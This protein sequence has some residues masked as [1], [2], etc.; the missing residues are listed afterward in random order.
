M[1]ERAANDTA[2]QERCKHECERI[3]G[4]ADRDGQE[5]SPSNLVGKGRA[6]YD[7]KKQK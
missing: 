3:G 4:T 7:G 1:E 5:S 2:R 6:T